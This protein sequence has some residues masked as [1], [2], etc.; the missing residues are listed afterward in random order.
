M[1]APVP[2]M[3]ANP[4]QTPPQAR[5]LVGS[6]YFQWNG[7]F[8]WTGDG[9]PGGMWDPQKF[10]FQPRAGIA[11]RISDRTAFR[12]GYARY[13][14][15]MEL[16]VITPPISG[17]ETIGFLSPP[18]F[19]VTGFQNPAPLIQGVPQARF[20]DPFPANSNPLLPIDGKASGSNVGRGQTAACSGIRQI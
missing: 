10:T 11:I 14:T 7:L 19:G 6:N 15:P 20:A 8:Q 16:G 12:A 1:A 18:Y 17:F 9:N 5:S 2:E 13:I 3:Q 4:P